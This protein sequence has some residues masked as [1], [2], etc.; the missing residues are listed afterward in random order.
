MADLIIS[1]MESRSQ[2][3]GCCTYKL[4]MAGIWFSFNFRYPW[5]F[6][7]AA[8]IMEH[9][10]GYL[11]VLITIKYTTSYM[12]VWWEMEYPTWEHVWRVFKI[13]HTAHGVRQVI[14]YLV[15]FT[16]WKCNDRIMLNANEE[17]GTLFLRY[18]MALKVWFSVICLATPYFN[19]SHILGQRL[20]LGEVLVAAS[21]PPW[22]F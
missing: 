7:T 11:M 12:D 20:W 5:I 18:S 17:A 22:A 9:S 15:D 21:G 3:P 6:R 4:Y 13:T 2:V 1:S 16:A 10:H 19:P 14:H 8:W